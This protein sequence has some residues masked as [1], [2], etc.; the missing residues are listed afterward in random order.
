MNWRAN[1]RET[2][3]IWV[4]IA[5]IAVIIS[6]ALYGYLTGAWDQPPP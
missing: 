1:R 4:M 3:F 6:I 5:I 2:R